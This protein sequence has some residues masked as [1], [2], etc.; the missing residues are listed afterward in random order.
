MLIIFLLCIVGILNHS[1]AKYSTHADL[2]DSVKTLNKGCGHYIGMLDML[3]G[4][5]SELFI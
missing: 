3:I 5:G 1:T 2:E 4:M